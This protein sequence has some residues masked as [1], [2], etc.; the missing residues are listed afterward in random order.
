MLR[1]KRILAVKGIKVG[2]FAEAL[3]MSEKTLYNKL[4]EESEFSYGEARKI[5]V[6]L[7]EYDVDYMLSSE[8]E[9]A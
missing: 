6:M 5:K 4:I 7:P 1:L 3:G 2:G 9:S 8:P